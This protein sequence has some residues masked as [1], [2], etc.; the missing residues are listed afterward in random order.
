[1][2]RGLWPWDFAQDV[3]P[4]ERASAP[5][6]LGRKMRHLVARHSPRHIRARDH[7]SRALTSGM[8]IPHPH[9]YRQGYTCHRNS[10]PTAL[11]CDYGHLAVRA[12]ESTS[13]ST[14][15]AA[16]NE[17]SQHDRPRDRARVDAPAGLHH[18]QC[19]GRLK[20]SQLVDVPSMLV[21]AFLP[22]DIFTRLS[23]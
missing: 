4:W 11:L 16:R 5:G 23:P 18:R 15:L 3:T 10:Q 21:S 7:E 1:V 19:G 14:S 20:I 8:N 2:V 13:R 22:E 17:L 9:F 12:K 6:Q